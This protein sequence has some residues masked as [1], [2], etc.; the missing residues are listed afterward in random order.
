[1]CAQGRWPPYFS[2]HYNPGASERNKRVLSLK[3]LIILK[4]VCFFFDK[5]VLKARLLKQIICQIRN[6]K[7]KLT[8][9]RS[10]NYASFK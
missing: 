1:M 3:T 9:A 10:L 7:H 6:G 5:K 8:S 2:E 4:V